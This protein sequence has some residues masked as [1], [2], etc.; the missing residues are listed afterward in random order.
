MNQEFK[1]IPRSN[2]VFPEEDFNRLYNI[3]KDNPWLLNEG[4]EGFY[5]LWQLAQNEE[6]ID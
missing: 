1:P 4:I 3:H 5:H 2:I 6:Q